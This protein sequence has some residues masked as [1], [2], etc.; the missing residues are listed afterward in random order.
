MR[1][2]TTADLGVSSG[3]SALRAT[4]TV[5]VSEEA[6]EPGRRGE[7]GASWPVGGLMGQDEP[8]GMEPGPPVADEPW[9]CGPL[10]LRPKEREKNSAGGVLLMWGGSCL[11]PWLLRWD[12]RAAPLSTWPQ[13]STSRPH[14][15]TRMKDESHSGSEARAAEVAAAGC[16][17]PRSEDPGVGGPLRP[18]DPGAGG[19][20]RV[21]KPATRCLLRAEADPAVK[22]GPSER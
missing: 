5:T 20:L 8:G 4:K 13:T 18:E 9:G 6:W 2:A 7:G 14:C 17:T 19:P 12:C 16:G 10:P 22:L 15:C 3:T 1:S 21:D 11:A